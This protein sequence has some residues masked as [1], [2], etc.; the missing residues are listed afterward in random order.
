MVLNSIVNKTA[1]KYNPPIERG[2]SHYA[3]IKLD[4]IDTDILLS[5]MKNKGKFLKYLSDKYVVS[6]LWI[7]IEN[8]HLEIWGNE[9]VF[10][11]GVKSKISKDLNIELT[12]LM[13]IRSMK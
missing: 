10:R 13:F 6:Y 12:R 7:D 4:N 8:K 1:A 3:H 5:L 11:K 2:S 9:N